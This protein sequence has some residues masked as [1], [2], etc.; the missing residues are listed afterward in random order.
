MLK[1]S[2]PMISLANLITH[3]L[4]FSYP[5]F[6]VYLASVGYVIPIPEEMVLAVAGFLAGAGRINIYLVLLVCIGG[7]MLGDNI[8]YRLAS[9]R[10]R[11]ILRWLARVPPDKLEK[12]HNFMER[13]ITLSLVLMRFLIGV[14]FLGPILAGTAG[15]TWRKFFFS[16][17]L[18][19]TLYISGFIYLGFTFAD[20]IQWLVAE[21]EW[22]RKFVVGSGLVILAG[23]LVF[24]FRAKIKLL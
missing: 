4:N 22:F 3:A 1:L 2:V 17:L 15:V 6:F 19:V 13:N 21:I 9:R 5:G 8:L 16:D 7:V 24:H 14:R 10:N 20:E 12:Y 23:W 18:A 11:Y